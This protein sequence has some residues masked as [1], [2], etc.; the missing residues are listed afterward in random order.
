[1]SLACC[2]SI[3]LGQINYVEELKMS[4]LYVFGNSEYD[5]VETIDYDGMVWYRGDYIAKGLN[6][7]TALY[8]R[9]LETLNETEKRCRKDLEFCSDPLE[10][11]HIFLNEAGFDNMVSAMGDTSEAMGYREWVWTMVFPDRWD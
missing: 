11:C 1:M 8:C 2:G 7:D 3:K 10:G 4:N 5:T 6:M 9:V